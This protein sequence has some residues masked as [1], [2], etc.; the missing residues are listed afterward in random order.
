MPAQAPLQDST[1]V[2]SLTRIGELIRM[3]RKALRITAH[4]AAGAAG[5]SRVTLHRI[6]RGEASVTMGSYLNA[7]TALGLQIDVVDATRRPRDDHEVLPEHIHVADYPQLQRLAWHLPADFD[8]TPEE[9]LGLYERHWRHVD[10]AA[11]STEEHALVGRLVRL[12]GRG[13]LLV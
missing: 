10:T 11:M 12:L 3:R 6:E 1:A 2:A 7:M 13:R 5:M 4:A 9:A 8:L